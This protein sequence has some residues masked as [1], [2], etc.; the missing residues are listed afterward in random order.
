[1][2]CFINLNYRYYLQ[3]IKIRSKGCGNKQSPK[4]VNCWAQQKHGPTA[5]F[6]YA[7]PKKIKLSVPEGHFGE[8]GKQQLL[9]LLRSH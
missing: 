2:N 7:E 8:T 5:F 6:A 1:M 3:L 9:P 4:V